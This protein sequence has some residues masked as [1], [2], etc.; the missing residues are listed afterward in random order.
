M[1][2]TAEPNKKSKLAAKLIIIAWAKSNNKK[3]FGS[4]SQF[5]NN[6]KEK[7]QV[8]GFIDSALGFLFYFTFVA[9]VAAFEVCVRRGILNNFS[10]EARPSPLPGIAQLMKYHSTAAAAA[11]I[12]GFHN[13]I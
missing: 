3:R 9:V 2:G 5:H 13:Y 10:F 6:N 4:R 8:V 7:R 12:F 11:A 1:A